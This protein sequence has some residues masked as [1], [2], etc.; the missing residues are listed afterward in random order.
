[1]IGVGLPGVAKYYDI[2]QELKT[3]IAN[4]DLTIISDIEAFLRKDGIKAQWSSDG[5]VELKPLLKETD[6]KE[7]NALIDARNAARAE[8]NFAEADR[9]RDKLEKMG[10]QLKDAKNPD[11]GELVTTW[12]VKR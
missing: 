10:I 6:E 8:K 1:M 12:E 2:V 4:N 11:T 7:F 3:A 5:F 9:I